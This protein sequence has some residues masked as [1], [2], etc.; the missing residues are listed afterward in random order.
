MKQFYKKKKQFWWELLAWTPSCDN[1]EN[2]EK[3]DK[4]FSA[5]LVTWKVVKYLNDLSKRDSY[6]I[7][8]I[9]ARYQLTKRSLLTLVFLSFRANQMSKSMTLYL[10]IFKILD[11]IYFSSCNTFHF[12][13]QITFLSIYIEVK[14]KW[15]LQPQN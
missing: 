14:T 6:F 12:L 5:H 3:Y 7:Q 2:Y 9:F 1:H 13:W 15:T 11:L 8:N 4:I 10:K